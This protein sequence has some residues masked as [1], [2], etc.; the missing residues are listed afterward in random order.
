LSTS[1]LDLSGFCGI[2]GAFKGCLGG[3]W[4]C[5]GGS[6]CLGC[7][8]CHKRLKLRRKL[9]ECKPLRHGRTTVRPHT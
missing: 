7:I 4:G 8:F 3:V 6:G 1:Q 2:G 5:L 9:D